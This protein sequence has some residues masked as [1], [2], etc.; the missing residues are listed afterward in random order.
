MV[1]CGGGEAEISIDLSRDH[2]SS[3][4]HKITWFSRYFPENIDVISYSKY[5]SKIGY[6]IGSFYCGEK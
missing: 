4:H 3:Q 6:S 5:A 2:E 1:Y